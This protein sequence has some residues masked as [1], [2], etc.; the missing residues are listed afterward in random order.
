MTNA[1]PSLQPPIAGQ[2]AAPFAARL[3]PQNVTQLPNIMIDQAKLYSPPTLGSYW[4]WLARHAPER[5]KPAMK[6]ATEHSG[7]MCMIAWDAALAGLDVTTPP[8]EQRLI[9]YRRKPM[10]LWIEQ[11]AKFPW[12]YLHNW[13]DWEKIE[14]R[15]IPMP[16]EIPQDAAGPTILAP[17]AA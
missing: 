10:A 7:K 1:A 15:L 5:I 4:S 3:R 17:G 9:L 16:P 13:L 12:A 6:R 11:R 8:P 14:G 2:P